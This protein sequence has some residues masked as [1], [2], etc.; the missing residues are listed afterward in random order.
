MEKIT[1]TTEFIK[2]QDVLKLAGV[3]Y[4]G[5][6]AKVLIQEGAVAVNG[7]ICTQ[8]GRKLRPGDSVRLGDAELTVE[9][10]DR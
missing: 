3:V 5:G 1:I 4:T 7:E 9:Y 8:R 10:A 6:E 2:L